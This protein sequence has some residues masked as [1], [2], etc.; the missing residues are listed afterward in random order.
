MRRYSLLLILLFGM[1][2][3]WKHQSIENLSTYDTIHFQI[4]YTTSKSDAEILGSQ[5]ELSLGQFQQI[6]HTAGFV[7]YPPIDNLTWYFFEHLEDYN[8]FT[9]LET[10]TVHA[11]GAWYS[12]HD[13]KVALLQQSN[14]YTSRIKH[15]A[16]H[17]LSYSLGLQKRGVLYPF[18]L[19]EG[20]A[21]H[22]ESVDTKTFT[23]I[24]LERYHDLVQ[25][26]QKHQL[27]SLKK[28]IT[29]VMIEEKDKNGAELYAQAWGLVQFLY[30]R[31]PE[32][33]REYVYLLALR[34]HGNRPVIVLQQE[35][36]SSF[37][38]VT[39][40]EPIWNQYLSNL[41]L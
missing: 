14:G 40:L 4:L 32:R 13:N 23:D 15:E 8:H 37:G 34:P 11:D 35:F 21:T 7:I 28:F 27:Y 5:L 39:E 33:F 6:Y 19:N 9:S 10:N 31:N 12:T 38:T 3:S 30:Q 36:E 24:N 18:W 29:V 2:I 17:Q 1:A 41:S 22:F 20:L 25:A 26:Y 16:A